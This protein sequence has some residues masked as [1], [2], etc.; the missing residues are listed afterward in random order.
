[1]YLRTTVVMFAL[2]YHVFGRFDEIIHQ[3]PKVIFLGRGAYR[4]CE[5]RNV[6]IRTT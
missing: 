4:R 6:V 5:D 3:G 2:F 1:V